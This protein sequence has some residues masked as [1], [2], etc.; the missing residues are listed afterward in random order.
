[1]LVITYDENGGFYDHVAPPKTADDLA[2]QGF[3]QLGFRVPTMVIGPYVKENNISSV[4]YDHTSCLKHIENTFGTDPLT[5]RVT[6]ATDLTD[7][8]D[9][10]RLAKGDWHPPID[11]PAINLADWPT[12]AAA[13]ISSG[14]SQGNQH[15]DHPVI[16]WAEAHPE[17]VAGLD[18]RD[19]LP[20]YR[21]GI[22]DFLAQTGRIGSRVRVR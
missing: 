18:L 13:C 5:A 15:G 19:E 8:I 17:L 12:T 11:L 16:D 7:C 20:E 14:R 9:L 21:K 1:M 22:R 4:Q 3:D 10:D 6:A 2:A